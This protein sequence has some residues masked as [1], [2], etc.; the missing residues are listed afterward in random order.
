[1]AT[2]QLNMRNIT[3]C[4]Y[5][6]LINLPNFRTSNLKLDKKIWKDIDIS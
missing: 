4:F 3:F 6:D 1:M 2:K 5:N